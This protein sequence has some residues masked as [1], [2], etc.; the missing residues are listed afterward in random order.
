MFAFLF[1]LK[2]W[3]IIGTAGMFACAAAKRTRY[4][5]SVWQCALF[6]WLLTATGVA[7][8]KLLF[9]LENGLRSWDGV[10]FF[11]SVFL[12]P[13]LMPLIGLL[14][15]LKPGQTMDLCAPC[16]AIMIAV[17][18][19]NCFL[20]GCCGGLF[21]QIGY[22]GF[23]WPTQSMDSIGNVLILM[24]LLQKEEDGK[25][26]NIQYPLFMICYGIMRFLL[27]FLRDTPK[28]WLCLSH[29][30]WFS[31]ASVILGSLWIAAE[32]RRKQ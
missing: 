32:N 14:F 17:L 9:A 21:V 5:M 12:I 27:E 4:T 6:T 24:W 11:G 31:I 18:R 30:Q 8:A 7:G 1:T 25:Q 26:K 23:R 16:V 20:S 3:L 10:S 22:S 2:F 29:G 19:V 15:R 28:N 13:I